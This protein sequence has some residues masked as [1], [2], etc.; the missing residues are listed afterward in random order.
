[1]VTTTKKRCIKKIRLGTCQICGTRHVLN[2]YGDIPNHNTDLSDIQCLGSHTLPEE[3]T[4][5]RN[6]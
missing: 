6:K 3:D 4:N 2:S 5:Y 1:M